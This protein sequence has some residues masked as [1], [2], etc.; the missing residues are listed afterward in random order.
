MEL[1]TNKRMRL[2]D[3][4]P[5]TPAKADDVDRELDSLV[6]AHNEVVDDLTELVATDEH[7]QESLDN[8]AGDGRT[9]ETVKGTYDQLQSVDA[10]V[11]SNETS[12]A[13]LDTR[14]AGLQNQIDNHK[15]SGDHDFQYFRKDEL[16]A[17]LRGGDTIIKYDVFTIVSADNG[18]GTFTYSNIHGDIIVGELT[19][20]GHQ[21]FVLENGVYI[22]NEN[23]I[24][25]IVSDTL[26][27]SVASG[28]LKELAENRIALTMPEGGGAEI[29]F[30]YYEKIGIANTGFVEVSAGKP[31]A[32]AMWFKLV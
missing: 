15:T 25:A 28:G 6:D 7:L 26:H 5:H 30:K 17:Y 11:G 19:E 27:R 22:T 21:V 23:R 10:R 12:I 18:D 2:Y 13:S 3:F 1:S 9:T 31:G 14:S 24:E 8:L 4:I 20:E 16:L 29:T 32:G